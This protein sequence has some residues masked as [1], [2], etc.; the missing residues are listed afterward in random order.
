LHIRKSEEEAIEKYILTS[1]ERKDTYFC[2]HAEKSIDIWKIE[3]DI[4][5][6]S[7]HKGEVIFKG[8]LQDLVKKEAA[9]LLEN[10]EENIAR[11][12][13]ILNEKSKEGLESFLRNK[14]LQNQYSFYHSLY[15]Y[16]DPSW[17]YVYI[18]DLEA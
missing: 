4:Y 13:T 5:T 3:G 15:P 9:K 17:Q 6:G 10:S 12:K 8:T 7:N 2:Q 1:I 18:K 16:M 14:S 11:I